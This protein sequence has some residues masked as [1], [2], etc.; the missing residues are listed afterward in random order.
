MIHETRM[1]SE[2][3]MNHLVSREIKLGIIAAECKHCVFALFLH[4]S[5]LR[6]SDSHPSR[7]IISSID[8]SPDVKKLCEVG[9]CM[10]CLQ[11]QLHN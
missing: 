4:P 3:N 2:D 6:V 7:G 10:A 8:I 1:D 9:K 11:Q 5:S